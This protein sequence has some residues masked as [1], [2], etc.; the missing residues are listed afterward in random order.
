MLLTQEIWAVLESMEDYE[1]L[2]LTYIIQD[3]KLNKLDFIHRG[4]LKLYDVESLKND[5]EL[6]IV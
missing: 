2:Y 4:L 3:L 6:F 1:K 5:E